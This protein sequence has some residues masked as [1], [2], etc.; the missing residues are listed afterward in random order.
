MAVHSIEKNRL[1][2][3]GMLLKVRS[4]FNKIPNKDRD[5]RG[6]KATIA[7]SDCL[8]SGLVSFT[9]TIR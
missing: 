1:S 8:M 9:S 3:K 2:V 6:L 7:L 5:A 4:V